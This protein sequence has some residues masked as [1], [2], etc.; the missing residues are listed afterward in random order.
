MNLSTLGLATTFSLTLLAFAAPVANA[1]ANAT[2]NGGLPF[3]VK[4]VGTFKSPWAM[5]FLPDGNMLVTQKEGTMILFNPVTGT[6][7]TVSGTPAVSSKGQGA[8]MDIVPAPDF[9]ASKLLYFS[10]S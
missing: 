10:Y 3:E 7:R 8:L 4:P 2:A 1:Q 6:R 5:A 9:A